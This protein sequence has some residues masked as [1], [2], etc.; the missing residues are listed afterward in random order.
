MNEANELV[1]PHGII[2]SSRKRAKSRPLRDD[3]FRGPWFQKGRGHLTL[4][5]GGVLSHFFG[6]SFSYWLLEV[7][8]G[9]R[10]AGVGALKG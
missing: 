6:A 1:C 5:M 2:S 4:G 9:A 7:G 8:T 10:M 3:K